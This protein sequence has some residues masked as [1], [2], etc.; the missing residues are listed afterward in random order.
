MYLSPGKLVNVAAMARQALDTSHPTIMV[1][2][3]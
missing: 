1:I 3:R 2:A